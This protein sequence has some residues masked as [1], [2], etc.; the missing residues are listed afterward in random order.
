MTSK[1]LTA[2]FCE[3]VAPPETG[4]S[5]YNDAALPGFRFRVTV[6]GR[7]S[8]SL[9]Y[10]GPD[11]K[12][13][14]LTWPFPTYKLAEAR[15]EAETTLRAVGRGED[16]AAEKRA[17]KAAAVSLPG[18]VDA[19]CDAYIE[20]HLK[21]NVRR[22]HQPKGEIDNHIRPRIGDLALD[23][24]T[25]GHVREMIAEIGRKYPVAANRVLARTKAVFN[26]AVENDLALTNPA[27]G[28]KKPTREKPVART[29]SDDE[30]AAVWKAC[31]EL[32]YPAQ[33]YVRFLILTG[34]RRDDVRLMHWSEIDLNRA[35]WTI[36]AERYK[37][38]RAHLV[39]LTEAMVEML[40]SMPFRDRAGYV[41]SPT[42]GVKAYN[43]LVKPKRAI[44]KASEVT[45]WTL[46]D[47]RRTLRTGL[48]RL[49]F[50]PDISERV[51]GHAVGGTLG[52]TYDTHEYR[53]E[54]L[55]ALK[56]WGEHVAA[57]VEG[58]VSKNVVALHG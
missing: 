57:A 46:H 36:P 11:R 8:F 58:R 6:A 56:A 14:R 9:V 38:D 33:Q 43:N 30:L 23:E 35:D 39:P 1:V 34:Q 4:R 21:P 31:D 53:A 20:R 25:R 17:A 3:T 13:R 52:Q 27:L 54:R 29:L 5:T 44:D 55:A 10:R 40:E 7:R 22:W 49:R 16:P 28:V 45:G 15:S 32:G 24:I 51:I 18:T 42:A 50:R 12:Q 41:F 19:L 37:G 2:R 48:S 47:L 26:W